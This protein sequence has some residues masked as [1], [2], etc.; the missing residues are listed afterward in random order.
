MVVQERGPPLIG[1]PRWLPPMQLALDGALGDGD[2]QLQEFAAD[3]CGTGRQIFFCY[4]LNQGAGLLGE[5]GV[6]GFGFGLM[7]PKQAK[8]VPMP[9]QKSFWFKEGECIFPM[10]QLTGE[11][12]KPEA[13]GGG[14][15]GRFGLSV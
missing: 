6:I 8:A 1:F 7:L 5:L 4:R 10:L 13:V 3:A 14:E 2:A 11:E 15:R 12:Q 9:P